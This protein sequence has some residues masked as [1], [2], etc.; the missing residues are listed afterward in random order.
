MNVTDPPTV[1]GFLLETTVVVEAAYFT[2]MEAV[3]F[4]AASLAP[5]PL[6]AT[7]RSALA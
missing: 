4:E 5:S 2:V 6:K 7:K 3:P 1:D